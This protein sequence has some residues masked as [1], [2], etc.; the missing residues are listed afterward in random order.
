MTK[1]GMNMNTATAKALR[2]DNVS[3]DQSCDLC[4]SS[5]SA[6]REDA[7]YEQDRQLLQTCQWIKICTRL[8]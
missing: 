2:R 3:V 7:A 4:F 8:A 5:N 6:I 1:N